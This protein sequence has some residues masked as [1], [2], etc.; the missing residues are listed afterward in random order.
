[1]RVT[2]RCSRATAGTARLACTGGYFTA[3]LGQNHRH[4]G[5]SRLSPRVPPTETVSATRRHPLLLHR[6]ILDELLTT[7]DGQRWETIGK[8]PIAGY[9]A[10]YVGYRKRMLTWLLWPSP[11]DPASAG[12]R[13]LL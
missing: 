10:R 11:D 4:N 6:C 3:P 5:G 9:A 2:P 1:M 12:L 13:A 8:S 7:S